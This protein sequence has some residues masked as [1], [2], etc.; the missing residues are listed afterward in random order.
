M[1]AHIHAC[2]L[3]SAPAHLIDPRIHATDLLEAHTRSNC[4]QPTAKS[5]SL[6]SAPCCCMAWSSSLLS[7]HYYCARV[8]TRALLA[9]AAAT[10]GACTVG[11]CRSHG[12]ACMLHADTRLC[13][14]CVSNAS[15]RNNLSLNA[16]E[17]PF[18]MTNMRSIDVSLLINRSTALYLSGAEM[19]WQLLV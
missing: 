14:C 2:T 10:G 6:G 7:R 5:R 3:Q 13:G 16:G 9:A 8:C 11:H 4:R 15:M 12:A 19:H 18:I 17:Y 1:R